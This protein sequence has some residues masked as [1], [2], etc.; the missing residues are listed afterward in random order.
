MFLPAKP[1]TLERMLYCPGCT[2]PCCVSKTNHT[3]STICRMG[4]IPHGTTI[5]AQCPVPTVTATGTPT[6][7]PAS[8]VP[9]IVGTNRTVQTNQVPFSNTQVKLQNEA[10]LPQNLSKF[11][12]ANTI[13]QDLLNDPNS[14]LRQHIKGQ[15]I[16]RSTVFTLSTDAS[17]S[18]VPG[19]GTSNVSSEHFC[20]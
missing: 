7:S 15:N 13:T 18:G 20:T 12:D 6:I 5:N 2:T 10:R 1:Q 8:I 16:T 4:S 17:R 11:I 19:G 9:F 14:M 3:R